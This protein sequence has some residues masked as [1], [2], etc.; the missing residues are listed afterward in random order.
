[1]GQVYNGQ[2]VKGLLIFFGTLLGSILIIPGIL[3]WLY[4]IF[5]AYQTSKK[6]NSGTIPF[7]DYSWGSIISLIIIGLVT[8]ALYSAI[9]A[10]IEE[11]LYYY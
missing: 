11:M 10:L 3:I 7:R 4:G 8:V 2:A 9:L 6:M 1:M 5:D